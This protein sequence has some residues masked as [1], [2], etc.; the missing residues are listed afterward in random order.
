MICERKAGAKLAVFHFSG[1]FSRA[2]REKRHFLTT[3][4][5][6]AD[7]ANIESADSCLSTTFN[8]HSV[9]I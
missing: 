3:Y 4:T 7:I 5:D 9:I 1:D 8:S 2:N 6:H